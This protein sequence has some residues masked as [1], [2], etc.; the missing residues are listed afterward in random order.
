MPTKEDVMNV[1]KG[2]NDP[3]IGI[4]VVALELIY[5]IDVSKDGRVNIKMTFTTPMCPYGPMLLEE[6]II[7][8]SKPPPKI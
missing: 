4:D 5:N 7:E 3:E 8:E 1:L 2:V 6:I